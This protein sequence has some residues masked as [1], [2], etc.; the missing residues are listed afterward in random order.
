MAVGYR[1]SSRTGQ[2]DSF[3][4]TLNV[5]V[6]SGAAVDDIAIVAIEQWESANP[7]VTAP[8]G[9]NALTPVVSGSQKL[10][11]WWKRLTAA[12][13]GNYTFT[14]T[15][16]QWSQGQCILQT[17]AVTSGDPIGTNFN[18]ATSASGTTVP[19]TSLT[20][21]FIPGL[22]HF[23]ANEN[24]ATKTPPTN[25]TEVQ[26][27]DYLE[28][29]YRL[30]GSSGT[31]TAS[32]GTTSTS[33]LILAMLV[34]VEPASVGGAVALDGVTSAAAAATGSAAVD[35]P[36]AAMS[37]SA[38]DA[39][40]A[41]AA[42]RPVEGPSS[43]S[44]HMTASLAAG[45]ALA[46]SSSAAAELTGDLTI[47]GQVT[48]T[49]AVHAAA[50]VGGTLAATRPISGSS[51]AATETSAVLDRQPGL[52]GASAL[53]ADLLGTASVARGTAAMVSAAAEFTGQLTVARTLIGSAAA[54]GQAAAGLST[55]P[56]V[57]AGT[58]S[59]TDR[60]IAHMSPTARATT[61]MAAS[62]RAGTTMG[63]G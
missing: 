61:Q 49:G 51:S 16:S 30:P 42:A 29:N 37:S 33:T 13:T 43:S 20:V 26:D 24:A 5:P 60:V 32:G 7:A 56:L 9:F 18:S 46:A 36:I 3:V 8:S 52:V 34:A 6:P 10:K 55:S 27:A 28:T 17:G 48:F 38:A 58:M 54:A 23:I 41:L 50:E 40:A 19:S 39:T 31:F 15:G 12:D 25:H 44:A 63:G 2:S 35:R 57:L 53:A 21:A 45:R 22:A 11:V 62:D 14:W 59:A 4:T 1:S 47:S